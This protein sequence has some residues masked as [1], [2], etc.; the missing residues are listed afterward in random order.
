MISALRIRVF[1]ILLFYIG[2]I[3]DNNAVI[4]SSTKSEIFEGFDKKLSATAVWLV[5][6]NLNIKIYICMTCF[7]R[8]DFS[9][10]FGNLLKISQEGDFSHP[11]TLNYGIFKISSKGRYTELIEQLSK[12]K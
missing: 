10:G 8:R 2:F 12:P 1:T 3:Y 11:A 4:Q 9:N 5:N 7:N 6:G